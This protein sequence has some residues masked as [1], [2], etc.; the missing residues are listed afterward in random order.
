MY[1]YRKPSEKYLTHKENKSPIIILQG[2]FNKWGFMKKMADDLS[3]LGY[4]IYV[5]PE[6]GNNTRNVSDAADIVNGFIRENNLKNVIIVGH[7]KGGLIG[8]YILI[9]FNKE[10]RV[11]GLVAI[12][13]P[14]YGSKLANVY[15]FVKSNEYLPDHPTIKELSSHMEVNRKII[16]INPS[17]DNIVLSDKGAMLDGALEN[18]NVKVAGHHRIVFDKETK[19]KIIESIEKLS[20]TN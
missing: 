4:S 6:L 14:F 16:T 10:E 19:E 20:K 1:Y 8:K 17:E 7:S 18:I 12:A 13:T 3:N 9:Y 15:K 11:K 5:L 2:V